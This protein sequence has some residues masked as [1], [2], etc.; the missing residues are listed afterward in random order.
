[1]KYSKEEIE[2]QTSIEILAQ[3]EDMIKEIES[4]RAL[5]L[6]GVKKGMFMLTMKNLKRKI[7]VDWPTHPISIRARMESIWRTRC[8]EENAG[9]RI[10]WKKEEVDLYFWGTQKT[11]K[12]D[13]TG[14]QQFG[15]L[16]MK[17]PMCQ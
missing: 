4:G 15:F 9:F 17:D 12:Y 13:I 8:R 1:M 5:R 16:V 6:R 3:Y 14:F 2:L 10:V 7:V 11:F